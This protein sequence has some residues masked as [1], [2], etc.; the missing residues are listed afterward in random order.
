MFVIGITGG[1]GAGKTSALRALK[2][3]GALVLDCDEIY[4]ELLSDSMQLKSELETRFNGVL[5]DGLIDRKLLGE[6]VFSDPS[7]L[8]DLNAITHRYVSAEIEQRIAAWETQGGTV[9]A[10]DAIALIESGRAEKCDIAVGV[11]AP[12]ETRVRRIMMRDS[13]SRKQAEMRIKAQKP[14][15]FYIENCDYML[16]GIYDTPA[17]FEEKCREFFAKI[18]GGR[19]NA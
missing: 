12:I 7:A 18:I 11:T 6:I 1:T 10:V 2:A 13:I 9:A 17:E 5:S 15:E 14:A 8:L 16:E 4:H 19:E 3:L